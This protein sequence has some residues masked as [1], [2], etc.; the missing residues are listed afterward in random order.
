M[1][2]MSLL[3]ATDPNLARVV[4]FG[5]GIVTYLPLVVRGA[6]VLHVH[7]AAAWWRATSGVSRI[8]S[9]TG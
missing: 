9:R 6:N 7:M 5:R 2:C 3:I 8:S 4:A 1:Q